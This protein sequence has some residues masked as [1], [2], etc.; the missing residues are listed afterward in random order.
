[1]FFHPYLCDARRISARRMGD[2]YDKERARLFHIIKEN[3]NSSVVEI[4]NCIQS[5]QVL[6]D[7]DVKA[8]DLFQSNG[9]NMG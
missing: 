5:A 1:M 7:L 9:H 6:D 8:S 4:D 2:Y 3:G